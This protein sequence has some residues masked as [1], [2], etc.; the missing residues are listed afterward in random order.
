MRESDSSHHYGRHWPHAEANADSVSEYTN[1][2]DNVTHLCIKLAELFRRPFVNFLLEVRD[3]A[4]E[5][6][7]SRMAAFP[8]G[9][10]RG[11]TD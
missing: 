7:D 8:T 11:S 3:E 6:P 5:F 4:A 1:I 10:S 9:T 2:H